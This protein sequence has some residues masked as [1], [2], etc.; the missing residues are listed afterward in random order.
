MSLPQVAVGFKFLSNLVARKWKNGK[1]SF[2]FLT[3]LKR[4]SMLYIPR[5]PE[6]E[7]NPSEGYCEWPETTKDVTAGKKMSTKM[8][9]MLELIRH[10]LLEV[11]DDIDIEYVGVD[12][13]PF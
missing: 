5:C 11:E 9:N 7:M 13:P 4:K 6:T 1:D 12:S 3:G 2:I 10:H 8:L